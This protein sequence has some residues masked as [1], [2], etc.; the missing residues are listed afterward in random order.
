VATEFSSRGQKDESKVLQP[1]DVA[2]A[3]EAIVTQGSVSFL[4][5]MHL[6]PLRKS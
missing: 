3:V 2:H 1:E 4:S 6:R 5:E